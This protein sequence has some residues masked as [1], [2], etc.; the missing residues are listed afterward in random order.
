VSRALSIEEPEEQHRDHSTVK[1][2]GKVLPPNVEEEIILRLLRQ[3]LFAKQGSA[4]MRSSEHER[5]SERIST[6]ARSEGKLTE[7]QLPPWVS[8][9]VPPSLARIPLEPP[10]TLGVPAPSLF[11]DFI[12]KRVGQVTHFIGDRVREV[13]NIAAAKSLSTFERAFQEGS[14]IDYDPAPVQE[15]EERGHRPLRQISSSSSSR[16]TVLR[17]P[18][19]I[20]TPSLPTPPSN[21]T[22]FAKEIKVKNLVKFN[23]TPADLESF[24]ASVKRCLTA[25]NLPLYYGGWVLGEPDGDYQYVAPNT[26]NS[27]SNYY[28]GK[29]LCASIAEKFEG[30]ALT[31]WDDYDAVDDNPVPNC[32]KKH[33]RMKT[34]LPNGHG[35]TV[36]VS[37][38]DLIRKQFSGEIDARTAEIELGKF[39]WEPFRKDGLGLSVVAFRTAIDRLLKR[40]GKTSQFE[41]I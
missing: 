37:L 32:W 5:A 17:V 18:P 31:W 41:R 8:Q 14:E 36:E 26:P 34:P 30:M 25:Q 40:A 3:T 22:M 24:D 13:A 28:M 39:H 1:P 7:A 15:Q 23:G 12:P 19:P 4:S 6:R 38:Y 2:K 27:K 10:P 20:P 35:N 29:R 16:D 21:I 11:E 33:S 9:S